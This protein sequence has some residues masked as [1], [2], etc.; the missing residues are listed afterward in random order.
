MAHSPTATPFADLDAFTALP[1][2][3]GLALS[4]DGTRLVTT[5]ATLTADATRWRTALWE[6]DPA[7]ERPARRLTRGAAA[8]SS[9]VFAPDGTLLF[10]STRPDPDAGAAE[11]APAALWALP[12][13]GEARVVGTRPGGVSAPLVA[14]TGDRVVVT[15]ATMP[16]ADDA[17][18]GPTS[19]AAR[20]KA[21]EEKKVTA[22]LHARVPV[23][24]WD[25]DLGPDEPRFLTAQLPAGEPAAG[26]RETLRWRD[27][28]PAPGPRYH[29]ASAAL[30]PDGA[31]LVTTEVV[32]RPRGDQHVRMVAI[33]T[34]D[35]GVRVLADDPQ[36]E[37]GAVA[38][39]PD[40]R[41]VAALAES[42]STPE[43][44]PSVRLV[45]VALDGSG[46]REVVP[47]WD[48]WGAQ[49]QWGPGSDELF[50]AADDHGRA[51]VF[52]VHVATGEVTRLTGDHGA[53][54]SLCVSPDGA[55][56][57]AVRSA[58]DAPPAVVR[59]DARTAG[60]EPQHLPGPAPA[61][62][63]PGTLTE[64]T[65]TAADGSDLRAWL[66]LPATA[67]AEA[68][69]PLLLWVHGGPLSSWNSWSW[70]WNPWVAVARGYA[71]LLPDPGLSTGYGAQFLA[72]GWGAWGEAPYT[73]LMTVTDAALERDDLDAARTAAMGGSFG[74]YVANWIAGHTDRFR[75]I[76]THASLWSLGRFGATT[77]APW[78]WAR[79]M[80]PAMVAANDPSAHVD[81]ITT[82]V[83]VIHGDK[84]FRVP[85]GEG[86]ALWWALNENWDGDP[87][88]V[89]HRFLYYPDENHW[90]LTP[91]HAILW[92]E[93]VFAFLA[94]HVH[95][96]EL[97]VPDL[98]R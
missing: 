80:T 34:A 64:V 94:T 11:D 77:D 28:T 36:R 47:G 12:P 27:L 54:G 98:L 6:V 18:D 17:E 90:V 45:L 88:E 20:R 37:F 78:Y 26:A 5:V 40:G 50:L 95:G 29:E 4:A 15:S 44:P 91:Q 59:L 69:A 35:G 10:T 57:Y 8:E 81:R 24:Y 14:R 25:S 72:R 83:L 2:T 62:Q 87:A 1:R 21:R 58:V 76:V 97:Q 82:P 38:V 85:I 65:T 3:A 73:D 66:A 33:S 19:D 41:H 89:P 48:P 56:V 74:G 49:P 96:V 7:G 51:P 55:H 61:V 93:T 31:E 13:T 70:R 53:Y 23:R 16:G 79:E 67:S 42:R 32:A 84:D 63:L 39:S 22:V 60:G 43:R 9:P 71:V 86:L 30:T 46:V 68:P 92:Y 75:A 52:R